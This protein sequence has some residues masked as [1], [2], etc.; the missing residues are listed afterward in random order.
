MEAP[1]LLGFIK[2]WGA[3]VVC[4][5]I[6]GVL[7]PLP[8]A[9]YEISAH[10]A[11]TQ[12][13]FD[14]HNSSFPD[15]VIP[16]EYRYALIAGAMDEDSDVRSLYHFYDPVSGKGLKFGNK[17]FMPATDWAR[18]RTALNNNY[19]WDAALR[20]YAEGN[21]KAAF[22]ALGHVIHLLE[23]LGT[24]E[25]TRNDAHP[26]SSPYE[27]FTRN[28]VPV[29]P[30]KSPIAL[31]GVRDYFV[32]LAKYSNENFYSADTIDGEY[33]K[34]KSMNFKREGE[35]E[36]AL[37]AISG[38]RY[39]L[40]RVV[41]GDYDYLLQKQAKALGI[42][43][44]FGSKKVLSDY[45]RLL[46]AKTIQHGAGL[47]NL[48]LTE[49]EKLRAAET[50]KVNNRQKVVAR[51]T[52]AN[53]AEA[54][55]PFFGDED[56][57]D[58]L[59]EDDEVDATDGVFYPPAQSASAAK[60]K[61]PGAGDE[62]EKPGAT[63]PVSVTAPKPAPVPVC[64]Y[65]F[66]SAPAKTP[67]VI[68]EVAWMGSKA[69]ATDE[70]IE[71]KNIS[72][73]PVDISGWQLINRKG[74]IEIR[75]PAGSSI[76]AGGF[77]LLERTG[78]DTVPNIKAN[79]IYE[80]GLSNTDDG[81]HL[82]APGCVLMDAVEAS[83]AW[84]AGN[85]AERRT[86]ELGTTGL[87]HNYSGTV[88]GGVFGTPKRENGP[89]P[90]VVI[91]PPKQTAVGGSGG[92]G[93]AP[94]NSAGGGSSASPNAPSVVSGGTGSVRV[95]EILFD[96]EG[97]DAGKEFIELYNPG[98]SA[99]DLAGF[100]LQTQTAK[101][102][103]EDG[104]AIPAG[105]CFLITMGSNAPTPALGM[106]FASGSLN[107]TSGTV[108]V[109]RN[110]DFVSGDSDTD[111]AD[112]AAYSNSLSGFVP[113][114][115][116]ERDDA[117]TFHVRTVP[118]PGDCSRTGSTSGSAGASSG[119]SSGSS[120]GTSSGGFLQSVYFYQDPAGD[121]SLIDL[122]WNN[123]PFVP[124]RTDGAKVLVL[125]KNSAPATDNQVN[126][127]GDWTTTDSHVL[128]VRYPTYCTGCMPVRRS[129][130]LP[131]VPLMSQSGQG[132]S[133]VTYNYPALLEDKMARVKADTATTGD[134]IT[135]AYY[136]LS[137]SAGGNQSFALVAADPTKYYF[138]DPKPTHAAPVLTGDVTE[139]FDPSRN[140]LTVT[141]P[142]A[143]DL[144]SADA[145]LSYSF[146]LNGVL[147]GLGYSAGGEY[148]FVVAAGDT[149]DIS[150]S[151]ADEF[152]VRS[153]S[154]GNEWSFPGAV[155]WAVEQNQADGYTFTLGQA[156][157]N[158]AS[159]ERTASY[160]GISFATD[161][162]INAV[163]VRIKSDR[164]RPD[165]TLRMRL[166]AA[167]LAG[168]P[169]AEKALDLGSLPIGPNQDISFI[170]DNAVTLRADTPYW[171]VLDVADY[172]NSNDQYAPYLYQRIAGG[173]PY[174]GGTSGWRTTAR[175]LPDWPGGSDWQMKVGLLQL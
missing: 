92:T 16:A 87:W 164:G 29:I 91:T 120:G 7:Y 5:L 65:P 93:T 127:A 64:A 56:S 122:H 125:Y 9:D 157:Q 160:Q 165:A 100:S 145:L 68:N 61:T 42:D 17:R 11:L 43:N 142:L 80:G 103:F 73:S 128:S 39:Y 67:I 70:W 134:Y 131:D 109:V 118:N 123:Y 19:T 18:E 74:S 102:N 114:A 84:P 47:T 107:N 161:T 94:A 45:W 51:G 175:F 139:R 155:T 69:S 78:D 81:V 110:Q 15:L 75:F 3:S 35:Y 88:S 22:T 158:C 76:P 20:A 85:A 66:A 169:L 2:K 48:F 8:A 138:N 140:T 121:G 26:I 97:S 124:G 174:L 54:F 63:K 12:A 31:G 136:D 151:A 126:T 101:K 34:P 105:G 119:A 32:S 156:D 150:Y 111:I 60:K 79:L 14:F 99:V 1:E 133:A 116:I 143:T 46:S 104:N 50:V 115:S 168:A 141:L 132:V 147:L 106:R 41:S 40:A 148:S 135:I 90:V 96:A 33:A 23:D 153:V 170:F 82:Y 55:A 83:P 130:I 166:Y 49:G 4:V 36:Y 38:E 171:L 154:S 59:T 89:P 28:L 72:A 58:G 163:S 24:P 95:N 113:G 146:S 62:D 129:L 44:A 30:T 27:E 159:C 52:L 112:R 108:F 57:R 167:D 37:G 162:P 117:G 86:M 10:A 6:I 173:D 144:D 77:Y 137:Y 25:H 71:L 13:I 149:F 172:T 152:S 21:D 53:I 98:T